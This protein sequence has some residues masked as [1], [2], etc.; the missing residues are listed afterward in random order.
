MTD[1]LRGATTALLTP[2]DETGKID[3]QGIDVLVANQVSMGVVGLFVLGTA[4][5]GPML[6]VDER[7]AVLER[8]VSASNGQLEI[9]AH[10]GAMPTTSALE[11]AKHAIDHGVTAISSVP[12]VYYKPDFATV[13]DYYTSIASL[14][15]GTPFLAYNN[16][17]ATGLDLTPDQLAELVDEGIIDGVK[18]ASANLSDLHRLVERGVPVWM[19]NA[20]LNLA[21]LAIGAKGTISTITNVVPEPFVALAR[22]MS[23]GDLLAARRFQVQIDYCAF[24]LRNPTI[25]GLHAG[26]TLRGWPGG[27]PRKPLRM[28]NEAELARISEAINNVAATPS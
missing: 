2:C 27:S 20:D 7:K 12:P 19:A 17:A 25:G 5:Q 26:A 18:Q 6:S 21:A 9:V 8:I 28:P 11:L 10:V 4:G 22:A 23:A 24:R 1:I 16:P 14:S 13:K 3:F 15:K